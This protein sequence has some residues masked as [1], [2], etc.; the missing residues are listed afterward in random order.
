MGLPQCWISR[1][2]LLPTWKTALLIQE[3]VCTATLIGAA[4]YLGRLARLR[5]T[6]P[7]WLPALGE[8]ESDAFTFIVGHEPGSF[9]G[10][11]VDEHVLS[12]AIASNE[13]EALV[14]IEPFHGAGLFD[15]CARS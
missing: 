10:R 2:G 7:K 12:A 3:A 6:A 5:P 11:D 15:R 14:D 9:E 13:A 1:I 4:A 8:T